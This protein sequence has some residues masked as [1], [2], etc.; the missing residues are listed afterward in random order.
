MVMHYFQQPTLLHLFM[1]LPGHTLCS[2]IA[3]KAKR[4]R[5]CEASAVSKLSEIS[6]IISDLEERH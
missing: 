3:I 1:Q 5:D 4:Q 6:T 2:K